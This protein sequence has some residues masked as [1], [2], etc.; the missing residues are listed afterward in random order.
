ML[1]PR[2]IRQPLARLI[3]GRLERRAR[4][5]PARGGPQLAF[6]ARR[7]A[8]PAADAAALACEMGTPLRYGRRVRRQLVCLALVGG[9]DD[10][11]AEIRASLRA[12]AVARR[13][14]ALAYDQGRYRAAADDARSAILGEASGAQPLLDQAEGQ[15]AVLQPGWV[16]DLG[17]ERSRLASLRGSGARGSVLHLVAAALPYRQVGYTLR[18]Q[19]VAH[20][21]LDAGLDVHV[22]SR[23]ALPRAARDAEDPRGA[24]VDGVPYHWLH[25]EGGGGGRADRSLLES[26]RAA[27]VLVRELRPAVLQPASNYLQAQM[28]LALARPLGIPV[29]YEVRG[30]WEDSWAASHGAAEE[31][32]L[33]TDRYR[34]TRDAETAAMRAA[35][36]VVTLSETMRG[37]IIARGCDPG[38]VVIVPNAVDVDRFHPGPRDATLAASLGIQPDEPVVGY[39]SSLSA[40]E[41]IPHLLAAVARL[42]ATGRRLRILLVGDGDEAAT[43]AAHGRRLGLD[44]GTLLMPGAVPHA[45]IL[46]YYS[47]IDIFVVPRTRHRV[48]R[49]VTPLKPY[50]AMA[51]ERAV[52]VSDL[53]ALREIVIPGETGLTFRAEDAADLAEVLGRLLDDPALRTRLGRQA[54]EWIAAHRTWAENGRRYR[55]LFERLGV[56]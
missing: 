30:F 2:V 51:M 17:P 31:T 49:L 45:A 46:A 3:A 55:E 19:A 6:I 13:R 25:P 22:A 9:L 38:K 20:C 15:L 47:L 7:A 50:E 12:P 37:E 42:R 33:A 8:G 1:V 16:P 36:A 48:S 52:V 4:G 35:D 26:T 40:Y 43:I 11:A 5:G 23:A 24:L 44:D 27:A 54:R 41:G 14:S 29:V 34:M 53:P 21:Q 39:I 18:T 56:A 28:A 32:A 10:A